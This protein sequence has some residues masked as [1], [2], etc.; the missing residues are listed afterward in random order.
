V[1]GKS[2]RFAEHVIVHFA[3][4]VLEQLA[5]EDK[6]LVRAH[7]RGLAL[8]DYPDVQLKSMSPRLLDALEVEPDGPGAIAVPVAAEVPAFLV[9]AGSGL[10]HESGCIQIQTD[11]AAR[12]SEHGLDELRL[13]DV[14]AVRDYDSR[15][16]N[17]VVVHGDSPRAGY[18]PGLTVTMASTSNRIRPVVR[19]ERNVA[20]LLGLATSI[21]AAA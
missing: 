7:G 13:G 3:P 14:V 20:E 10:M 21:G 12:L 16:G 18:G 15:G 4:E 2:G 17:G 6:V 11:H 5:I 8:A 19:G 1:I 9:G